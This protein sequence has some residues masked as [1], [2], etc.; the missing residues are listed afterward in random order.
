MLGSRYR[1]T[2]VA[3]APYTITGLSLISLDYLYV[4]PI[5]TAAD[6]SISIVRQPPKATEFI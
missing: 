1:R 4:V 2:F 3:R 5:E 6:R